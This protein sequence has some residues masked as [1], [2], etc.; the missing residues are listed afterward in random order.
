MGT[1]SPREKDISYFGEKCVLKCCFSDCAGG[2]NDNG[3]DQGGNW[4]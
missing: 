1:H 2:G 3:G 4:D